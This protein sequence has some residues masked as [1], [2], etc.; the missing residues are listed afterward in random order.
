MAMS[1]LG[2]LMSAGGQSGAFDPGGNTRTTGTERTRGR[3]RSS[4]GLEISDEAVER[5]IQQTLGGAGGLAD[6]FSGASASGLYNSS[7]ANLEAGDFTANVVG[8]IARLRARDVTEDE[9]EEEG[10]GDVSAVRETPF[11][12]LHSNIT[13]MDPG[14]GLLWEGR[15]SDNFASANA[16]PLLNPLGSIFHR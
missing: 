3:S 7:S 2:P 5:I 8:E 12:G 10:T 16:N 9:F 14:S 15:G 6:I 1:I 13:D 4:Q 11:G